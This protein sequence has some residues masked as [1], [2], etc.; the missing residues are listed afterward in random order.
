MCDSFWDS[1]PFKTTVSPSKSL[2]LSLARQVS[3]YLGPFDGRRLKKYFV[4][5][6]PDYA[7]SSTSILAIFL[8]LGVSLLYLY[9]YNKTS[10]I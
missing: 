8:S 3:R 7:Y 2:T 5:L 1:F 6:C 4:K 10:E 9:F